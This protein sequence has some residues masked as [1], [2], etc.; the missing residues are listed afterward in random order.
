MRRCLAVGEVRVLELLRRAGERPPAGDLEALSFW[1]R[2][3]PKPSPCTAQAPGGAVFWVRQ[4][5]FHA[6]AGAP[7][8]TKESNAPSRYQGCS[9]SCL[10]VCHVSPSKRLC[11]QNNPAQSINA[12][13]AA[14][15]SRLP[16]EARERFRRLAV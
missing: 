16:F 12:V 4:E 1:V 3:K 2:D 10:R 13:H 7:C 5:P 11:L 8:C 6:L 15:G 14:P 9:N